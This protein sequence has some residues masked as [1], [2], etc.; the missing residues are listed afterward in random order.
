MQKLSDYKYE[1][2]KE[3][4]CSTKCSY[5]KEPLKIWWCE[6]VSYQFYLKIKWNLS[7]I[8][9]GEWRCIRI[10]WIIYNLTNFLFHVNMI[11]VRQIHWIINLSQNIDAKRN[12]VSKLFCHITHIICT[13]LI[14][15]IT[16]SIRYDCV[17]F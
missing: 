16:L 1:Q 6:Y 5:F 9:P 3:H 13:K 2:S 10:I 15:N 11:N 4:I 8:F 7:K 17:L 14:F 12:S